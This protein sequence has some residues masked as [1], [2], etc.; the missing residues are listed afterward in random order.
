M[1]IALR[2]AFGFGL[3]GLLVVLLGLFSLSQMRDMARQSDEVDK[4]WLP[5]ILAL[6]DLQTAVSEIRAATYR[7]MLV[8]SAEQVKAS[9][10]AFSQL[11][12]Q[13]QADNAQYASK[14]TVDAERVTFERFKSAQE[15]YLQVQQ[16]VLALAA[17]GERPQAIALL[18]GELI[19][20][21]D[22]LGTELANLLSINIQEADDAATSSDAT[23]HGAVKWV[24]VAMALATFLTALLA[25][26]FTRSIVL[27]LHQAVRIA[28]QVAKG[29]LTVSIVVDGND[30]PGQLLRALETMQSDLRE[31]IHQITD[32]S[33]QLASAA[34]ELSAVTE[35]STRALH[36]QNGEI[37]Q[38]ATAVN[39]MT[40][41]VDEV[42]RNAISTADAS[43]D[44]DAMAGNGRSHVMDTVE[45]ISLL[46]EEVTS[47]TEEIQ[48]LA[49][50]V[51]DITKVLDVIRAIAEQT[52]LLALN[53]AIEAARAGEAGRGFA[54][55]AD[56]VR[57]LAH[58]TQ[59][60]TQEIEQ[61]VSGVQKGS[62]QAVSV[63]HSSNER[64]RS[65]LTVAHCAGESL[66]RITHAITRIT[67]GNLI[68][69]SASEEQAQVAREVD[70]NLTNIRDLSAQ[71][72][73]GANQTTA[74]S[75]ELSRLAV[76]LNTMIAKF[77][78]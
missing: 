31:T 27:P 45:S 59:Q 11:R 70:R 30:E 50:S 26:L 43:R 12:E 75:Q 74:A 67:E 32:S 29:D 22:K 14:L 9:Q 33:N 41:A 21:G 6:G 52:N 54:V 57:A 16:Q 28:E 13:I 18:N 60:S 76:D 40:A 58:R 78:V 68:I 77:V 56:E 24:F 53:A 66:E 44:G 1:K 64:A 42:A 36:E 61:M 20:L 49:D 19:A 51:Q 8:D 73:A 34:E 38:A 69:A 47:A 5:S 63:M 46:A 23:Y 7:V 62:T 17:N 39:Q 10:R 37:E 55:V 4:N 25:T 48:S 65:T 35:E 2:S 3:V 72:A 15:Q 71:T